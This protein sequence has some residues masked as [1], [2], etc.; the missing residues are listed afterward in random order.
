[1]TDDMILIPRT[2]LRS[3]H[4]DSVLKWGVGGNAVGQARKLLDKPPL[5]VE[6]T[7]QMFEEEHIYYRPFLG[8]NADG[9]YELEWV[10]ELWRGWCMAVQTIMID[11]QG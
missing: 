2:L 10:H 7:R 5:T 3:L 9:T 1:M 8:R 11:N 4:D 6:D